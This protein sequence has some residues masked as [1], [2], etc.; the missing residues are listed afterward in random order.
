MKSVGGPEV[1][2][3]KGSV[4]SDASVRYFILQQQFY[5]FLGVDGYGDVLHKRTTYQLISRCV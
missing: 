3:G 4:T 5:D 2:S 1:V